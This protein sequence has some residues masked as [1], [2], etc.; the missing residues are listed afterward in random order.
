MENEEESSSDDEE[1]GEGDDAIVK[2]T[3]DYEHVKMTK[4]EII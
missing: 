4:E 1:F 3:N 2:A